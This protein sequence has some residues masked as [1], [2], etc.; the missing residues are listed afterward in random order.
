VARPVGRLVLKGKSQALMVF[1]PI[2][3]PAGTAAQRDTAYEAAYD[4]L[5]REDAGA[6]DAFE[7]LS[8]ERPEDPLVKLHLGR[9]MAGEAGDRIVLAEK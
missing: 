8:R 9:L 3:A 2:V 4:L 5:A 1:E 6:Q 7:A